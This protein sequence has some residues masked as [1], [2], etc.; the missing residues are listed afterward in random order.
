MTNPPLK[1]FQKMDEIFGR[2]SAD[3]GKP[4]VGIGFV[5]DIFVTKSPLKT[6]QKMDELLGIKNTET[7]GF[8][9]IRLSL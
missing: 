4:S 2:S 3:D 9:T 6:L 8:P 1:T 7:M 5:Y